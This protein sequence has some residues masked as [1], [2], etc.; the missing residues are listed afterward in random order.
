VN[1]SICIG[2]KDKPSFLFAN[3]TSEALS[4]SRKFE[5]GAV[6]RARTSEDDGPL[7]A[8]AIRFVEQRLRV[9]QVGGVEALG[10]PVVDVGEHPR[11]LGRRADTI[12]FYRR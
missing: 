4:R 1:G 6:I 9:F 10:E 5:I 2:L 7:T 11:A 3:Y 12:N 8:R